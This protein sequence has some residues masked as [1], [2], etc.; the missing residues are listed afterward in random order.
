M[1]EIHK[2]EREMIVAPKLGE[3]KRDAGR[4]GGR[5]SRTGPWAVHVWKQR[6]RQ[7]HHVHRRGSPARE[8]LGKLSSPSFVYPLDGVHDQLSR[9]WRNGSNLPR[10]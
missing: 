1:D 9:L 3:R 8:G 7:E 2:K 6:Q 4:I 10:G 5:W